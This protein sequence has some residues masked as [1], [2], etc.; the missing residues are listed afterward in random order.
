MNYCNTSGLLG[1][2]E[3]RAVSPTIP[4]ERILTMRLSHLTKEDSE[5]FL[6]SSGSYSQDG[7][8]SALRSNLTPEH[9]AG[10]RAFTGGDASYSRGP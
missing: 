10:T 6:A 4:M 9:V 7:E 5:S 3:L 2:R 8:S 1:A